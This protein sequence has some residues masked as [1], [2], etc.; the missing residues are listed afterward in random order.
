MTLLTIVQD[1]A[2]NTAIGIPA[3]AS[4]STE[5]E[6]VNIVQFVNDTGL[7]LARRVDWGALRQTSTKTGTGLLV[8]HTMPSGYSR[9][10]NG[11]A[12]SASGVPVRGGL[13]P[14]EWASLT[15]VEGTP[16]FFRMR[17]NTIS[18]YPFLATGATAVVTF[19]SEHWASN[20][21]ERLNLD[22]ETALIPEDLITK[23]AIWRQR[24]HVGQDFSDQI[25][26]YEAALADYAAYDAR[27]RSP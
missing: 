1:V 8:A 17:G 12:V 3:T 18:F 14:D 2:R 10:I 27:D 16:R 15:P 26:E 19:Q 6:I 4:G 23:G 24:R 5:R 21:T 7:E 9:L 20:G 13:S 11:N 25:A 22:A